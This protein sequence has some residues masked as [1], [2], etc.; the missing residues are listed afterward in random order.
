[1][2]AKGT[3]R[4]NA[5]MSSV[6][7]LVYCGFALAG[8]GQIA[9]ASW[10]Y[11]KTRALLARAKRAEGTYVGAD[12]SFTIDNQ[13][14]RYDSV[15]FTT[16]DGRTLAISSR[17][18]LPWSRYKDKSITVLYDPADP[19]QGVIEGRLELWAA[20][21]IFLANGGLMFLAAVVVGTLHALGVIPANI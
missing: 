16:E 12:S 5:D 21:A 17:I 11:R 13:T 2:P 3:L 10:L 19:E 15:A 7:L 8:L 18:G 6:A 9:I 4:Y 1:M 14:A 20:P